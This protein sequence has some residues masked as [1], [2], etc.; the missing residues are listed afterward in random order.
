MPS[1][2]IILGGFKGTETN[3]NER[4]WAT[5]PTILSGDLNNSNSAN[6]GD[7]HTLF[8]IVDV[9]DITLDGVIMDHAFADD[10]AT[11]EGFRGAG[12][13]ANNSTNIIINNC[14]LEI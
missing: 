7:S 13:F 2:I 10:D 8:Y 5:N 11:L 6:T 3:S 1:G 12:V 4:N 9:N 14:V